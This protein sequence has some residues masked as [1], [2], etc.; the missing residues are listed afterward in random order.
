MQFF[1]LLY[2]GFIQPNLLFEPLYGI[3]PP[4]MPTALLVTK[5]VDAALVWEPFAST[6]EDAGGA[7]IFDAGAEWEKAYGVKYQRN[8]LVA[9]GDVLANSTL[10][11][12]IL[13]VHNRT[14]EFLNSPG[15]DEEIAKA[16]GIKPLKS[17]RMEYNS[18]LDWPSMVKFMEN[19][20]AG[21]YLN[22]VLSKEELIHGE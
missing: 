9:N 10:L 2:R 4:D 12:K 17:R 18:S 16:M 5:D 13:I 20:Q 22:R 1:T 19:A 11:S 6:I 7:C 21:G 14:V 8:V 15:S 3:E